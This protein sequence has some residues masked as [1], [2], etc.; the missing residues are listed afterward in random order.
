MVYLV[1]VLCEAGKSLEPNCGR[2][3]TVTVQCLDFTWSSG[4]KEVGNQ[5][6]NWAE[7]LGVYKV[8]E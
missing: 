7:I 5:I 1:N 2:L 8:M 6:I 3:L 4:G